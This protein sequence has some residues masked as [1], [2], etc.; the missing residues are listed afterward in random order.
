M[1]QSECF[2]S[3][4]QLP[5]YGNGECNVEG[6]DQYNACYGGQACGLTVLS[7]VE[8]DRHRISIRPGRQEK[9]QI[10]G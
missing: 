1:M 4:S 6:V 7:W 8:S 2:D 5:W 9:Q 3:L 10:N